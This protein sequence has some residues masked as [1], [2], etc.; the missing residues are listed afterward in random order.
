MATSKRQK[1]RRKPYDGDPIM[2][3]KRATWGTVAEGNANEKTR[4]L[5][6]RIHDLET[7]LAGA[8]NAIRELAL[9][10]KNLQH[11]LSASTPSHVREAI[12]AIC[13]MP[14]AAALAIEVLDDVTVLAEWL[15]NLDDSVYDL[16]TGKP[17][18]PDSP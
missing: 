15:Q 7:A 8:Q 14:V 17:V 12:E 4:D 13:D 18:E 5:K 10:K 3:T 11:R 1:T 6:N 2:V 9:Q 16:S